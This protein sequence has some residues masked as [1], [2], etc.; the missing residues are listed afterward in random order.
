MQYVSNHESPGRYSFGALSLLSTGEPIYEAQAQ[1]VARG[2]IPSQAT[3]ARMMSDTRDSNSMITW[4]RGHTLLFLAEYYLATQDAQVQPAIEAYAVNIAKNQS[5][6]G[7][8]GH[9]FAEKNDDGSNNGPMGGV[10]GVV[11]SAGMP[12]FLGV[13]LARECGLTNPEL[14]TAI[15]ASS[16]FLAYYSGKGAIPY[17]EHEP[18]FKVHELNGK[19]GLG[20]LYFSLQADRVAEGQF[21]AQMATASANERELG[22]TGAWFNFFWA[23]LGA[24]AGGEEAAA[25]YFARVSWMLDLNRCWDGSFQYD[26]LNG[27][28]PNS[29]SS[30]NNFRMSTAALLTYA[31]P[32]RQLRITGKNHDSI[33]WLTSAQVAAAVEADDYIADNRSGSELISDLVNWSPKVRFQASKALGK[34]SIS[35]AE[36][37]QITAMATDARAPSHSRAGACFALGEIGAASSAAPLS[38]LLTD[39]DNYVRYS[40]AQ[41]MRYLPRSANLAVVDTI[42]AAA[43]STA[44]P[45]YPMVEE[46][47]LQ[48]AHGKIAILLFYS[49]N[50]YGPKGILWDN[51][52]GINRSLLYPAIRAVANNPVGFARSTL[53]QT[54]KN[55]TEEEVIT[56]SATIIDSILKRAPADKMFSGGIRSGGVTALKKFGIAE[57]VPACMAYAADEVG[58]AR[59][60]IISLLGSF[61]GSVY[62]VQPDPDVVGFLKSYLNDSE[63]S[64]TAR[65]AIDAIIADLNPTPLTAL[66]SIESAS[67]DRLIMLQPADSNTVRVSG[68]DHAQGDSIYTWKKLS[69]PSPVSFTPNGTA[70]SLSAVQFDGTPGT[71]ELEVTMSDS[72]GLT[73][74]YKTFSVV[75]LDSTG[76]INNN[77]AFQYTAPNGGQAIYT[78]SSININWNPLF[79]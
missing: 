68:K 27:E 25:A 24:A 70:A 46:D 53:N 2:L 69:G 75:V 29:G 30:Y 34:R 4:Q 63:V 58:G 28:G 45:L 18:D 6:F 16:R 71:Y 40:A 43:A 42:L 9:I 39:P 13:L 47:P 49:G 66:K 51:L 67:V 22:H 59:R 38:T 37:D 12:C 19:C 10:Y 21:F 17:G 5:L 55:L 33:R 54:Y 72:R 20:A 36:L 8:V 26:C 44:A 11:N 31:L 41:A 3:M 77:P 7:T 48:F 52:S 78:N 60:N 23:P 73:E 64:A 56:V 65:E 62:S 76:V 74:A 32:H 15:E 50:A 57:G 14:Q 61:G 1:E 79:G 35:A